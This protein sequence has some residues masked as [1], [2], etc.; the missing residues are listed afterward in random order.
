MKQSSADRISLSAAGGSSKQ[1]LEL[2]AL[3][4]LGIIQSLASGVLTATEAVQRFYHAENCLYVR[5]HLRN[6]E[7][8]VIMGHGVQLPDLFDSLET[9]EAQRELYHELEIMRSRCLS[10]LEKGRAPA[11]AEHATA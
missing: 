4:N 8:D 2:F 6:R 1:Q 9:E 11:L 5:K 10:L 7:A 3:V